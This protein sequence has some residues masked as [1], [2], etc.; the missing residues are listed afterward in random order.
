MF[1]G[2]AA[3]ERRA[4]VGGEHAHVGPLPADDPERRAGAVDLLDHDRADD[5]LA[6]RALDL[7][8]RARKLVETPPLMVD[9]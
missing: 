2:A 5:D 1:D 6:R 3:A 4:Q 8:A 7:D 9:R